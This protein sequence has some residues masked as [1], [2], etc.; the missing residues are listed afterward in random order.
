[1]RVDAREGHLFSFWIVD[2]RTGQGLPRDL[3]PAVIYADDAT[4]VIGVGDM[5]KLL[6]G[7]GLVIHEIHV[8]NVVIDLGRRTVLINV[9]PAVALETIEIPEEALA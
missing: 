7:D 9:D 2:A 4:G 6:Q 1:M 8:P 3:A 5:A